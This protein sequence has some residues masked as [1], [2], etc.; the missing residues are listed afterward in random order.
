[1]TTTTEESTNLSRALGELNHVHEAAAKTGVEPVRIGILTP[2]T[3]PGDPTAGELAMRAARVAAEYVSEHR[4]LGDTPIDYVMY[5]DQA[6]SAEEGMQRSAVAGMAKLAMVDK[7]LAVIGNWHLRTSNWVAELAEHVGLPIFIE[8]GHNDVTKH[9]RTTLFR[10][11]FS[12]DDRVPMMLDFIG[13]QGMRRIAMISPSDTVL[14]TMNFDS[15]QFTKR[16]KYEF[17]YK[18]IEF[19][20]EVERDFRDK[21]RELRNFKPDIFINGGQVTTNYLIINQAAEVGL[22]PDTPMMVP[23]PYP[24]RSD[25]FWRFGGDNGQRIIWPA[26]QYRPSWEGLTPVGKWFTDRYKELYGSYPPDNALNAFT[27]VTIIAQ[28]LANAPTRDRKGLL[29][30]LEQGTFDTWRGPVSFERGET[31]WHHSPPEIVLMQYQKIGQSFDDAEI[32]YPAARRTA[33]YMA[34]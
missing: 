23:F 32:I 25:D 20:H 19:E 14:G 16:P 33:D 21:L 4:I 28:A 3:A 30:E 31:H 13:E 2:L 5:N 9:Q 27:D 10:T 1:M 22:L 12:I 17:E 15:L 26:L 11:Y 18:R 29:Y 8:N 24:M 7:V 6:T 34:P